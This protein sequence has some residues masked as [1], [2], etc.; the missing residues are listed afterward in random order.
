MTTPETADTAIKILHTSDWHLGRKLFGRSRYAETAHFLDWLTDTIATQAVEVLLIAGD[1]FDSTTPSH[2]A[3]ELYY[4]FLCRVAATGCRHIVVIAGNHD[5]PTLI[6]APKEVLHHLHV[7]VIGAATSSPQD[8]LLL[9][10]DNQGQPELIVCA[11][12]YLRDRDV[13]RA[14]AGESVADKQHKLLAGIRQHYEAVLT[15]AQ[16]Q[17]AALNRR[18]PIIA[19]GHLFTAGGRTVEGDGVRELYVGSLVRVPADIFPDTIDYLALGHLHVPQRVGSVDHRRYSGSPMPVNFAEAGQQK[20]VLTATVTTQKTEVTPIPVPCFQPLATVQGDLTTIRERLDELRQGDTP[21]WVEVI[22]DGRDIIGN[23]AADL[24]ETVAGSQVE[25]LRLRNRRLVRQA[26]EQSAI[27]E[28]LDDLTPEEVFARC[29]TAHD[30]PA[31]QRD[32]LLGAFREVVTGL[33]ET[34]TLAE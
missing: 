25:I 17:Q 15:L 1:V 32:D 18:V 31:A 3:Q 5:S 24:Q 16:A 27:Q 22:Y 19:M 30:V 34:D 26:L 29:L 33:D 14:E 2:R 7:H 11:V 28:T 23:L 20:I 12:P 21:V 9:L 13:R 4:R 6:D 10:H 8:E